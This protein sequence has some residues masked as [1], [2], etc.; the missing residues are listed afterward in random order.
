MTNEERIVWIKKAS[1]EEL[2][3][4]WRFEP[5]GSP[6]FLDETGKIFKDRMNQLK[7]ANPEAAVQASKN[8]GW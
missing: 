3:R 6:W 8:I 1:Y 7:E 5:S 2:L 4:L